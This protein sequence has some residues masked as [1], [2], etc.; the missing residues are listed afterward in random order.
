[1]E[2]RLDAASLEMQQ[3]SYEKALAIYTEVLAEV[4]DAPSLQNNMGYALMQ[5]GR[6]EEALP[7]FEAAHRNLRN[8]REDVALLHNWANALEKLGRLEEAEG[9]YAKAAEL[10]GTRAEVYINWGNVL[11][12]LGRLEEAAQRYEQGVKLN[13]EAAIG[14]FNWGYTLERL[15]RHEEALRCY[16]TFLSVADGGPSDLFEHARDFVAQAEG[17]GKP[18]DADL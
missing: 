15:E 4:P 3:G 2:A 5:L 18:R 13:P 9:K 10:D 17:A 7:H 11:S 12:Q 14:W 16:R 1:M 6:F 8:G